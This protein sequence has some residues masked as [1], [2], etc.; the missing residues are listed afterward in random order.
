VER[1]LSIVE[2]HKKGTPVGVFSV[3]SANKFVIEALFRFVSTEGIDFVLLESSSNQ[4][5]QFGGYTGMT[6]AAFKD[7]VFEIAEKYKVSEGQIVLGG[8]HLGPLPWRNEDREIALTH[9]RALVKSC[10][11]AGY[12]KIHLDTCYPLKNDEG[13]SMETIAE[14]QALLC[15]VAEETFEK[16]KTAKSSTTI[17]FR[18]S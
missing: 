14:R 10:V 2:A 9:A 15:A 4:V 13:F 6:P 18:S 17:C 8:D 3:C 1:L 7:F 12:R 5:N 16:T 11:E